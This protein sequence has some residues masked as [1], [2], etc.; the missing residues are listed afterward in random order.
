[1]KTGILTFHRCINYGSYW[2]TRC[3]AEELKRR[4]H[5]VSI[6]DH[7]SPR[8]NRSEWKCA[9]QPVLPTPVPPSDLPLYRQKMEKFFQAFCRLPL[10]HPFPLEHP[11]LMDEYDLVIVGSDEV[12]NLSHPWY[13]YYPIFYGEGIRAKHLISYAASFGNYDVSWKPNPEWVNKLQKFD[14][15]SVR[16]ENSQIIVKNALGYEPEMVLDPCLLFPP[17]HSDADIPFDKPYVAVYGHNFSPF[18]IHHVRSW[19]DAE[20]IKLISIG[21]RNDWADEQ[22]L[23]AGPLEFASFVSRADAV[24]TNFFHGCIFSLINSKPFVVETTPYRNH[25]VQDLI[26]K[27]GAEKH[28][29]NEETLNLTYHELLE[30]R[31]DEKIHDNITRLRRSSS[32]FLDSALTYNSHKQHESIV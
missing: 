7:Y 6:L 12:W 27:T 9:L 3:L 11:S 8:V 2:Q 16:D 4:G 17:G 15:I 18:F 32:A 21:Y 22:W 10:S 29:V 5:E 19:A 23:T 26:K 30:N 28:I 14:K 20:R 25:K 31:P 24:V 1:M 13:G